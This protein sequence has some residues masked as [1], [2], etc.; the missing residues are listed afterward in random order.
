MTSTSVCLQLFSSVLQVKYSYK[1]CKCP[2]LDSRFTS[3]QFLSLRFVLT[4][5]CFLP[6]NF[7]FLNVLVFCAAVSSVLYVAHALRRRLLGVVMNRMRL[8]SILFIVFC[9]SYLLHSFL[10]YLVL[11]FSI[12][13]C[14]YTV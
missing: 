1:L 14:L 6:D 13:R 9:F 5:C 11:Y 4:P 3:S 10:L 2:R 12:F 8:F 7:S